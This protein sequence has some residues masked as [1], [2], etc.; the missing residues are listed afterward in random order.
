M[1]TTVVGIEYKGPDP[2]GALYPHC[3]DP[4]LSALSEC[5]LHQSLSTDA[6]GRGALKEAGALLG[7]G[8]YLNL[9]A[10]SSFHLYKFMIFAYLICLFLKFSFAWGHGSWLIAGT[11]AYKIVLGHTMESINT[12]WKKFQFNPWL[13]LY[14][15]IFFFF[16]SWFL[17]LSD[18]A[19][20][21]L[22]RMIYIFL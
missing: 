11:S 21:G 1:I 6:Q 8:L 16:T 19:V 2:D 22:V 7:L 4:G 14:F 9:P 12:Y 18:L 10:S 15:L 17:C 5:Q 20:H 3:Q 13:S